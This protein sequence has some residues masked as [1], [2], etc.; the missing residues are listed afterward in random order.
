LID[1]TE[2]HLLE[3]RPNH[4]CETANTHMGSG[5]LYFGRFVS[6][7]LAFSLTAGTVYD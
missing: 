1:M 6:L 3:L 4:L 7:C 2:P 5:S